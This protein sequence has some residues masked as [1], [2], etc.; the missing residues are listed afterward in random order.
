MDSDLLKAGV[1]AHHNALKSMDGKLVTSLEDY[2]IVLAALGRM[3]A[4][5]PESKVMSVYDAFGK[6]VDKDVPK[7][8]MATVKEADAQAAYKGLMEFKDV[9]KGHPITAKAVTS[10]ASPKIEA[11]AAKLA[12][13]SYPFLQDI[14]WSSPLAAKMSG[15][16]G[17]TFNA[18]K[19]VD[20]A[21]LMGYRVDGGA[22]KEAAEAHVK[23]I[24]NMDANGV[25]TKA[26]YQAILA[27]LGKVVASVPIEKTTN[28]FESFSKVVDPR[29]P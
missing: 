17:V 28:V 8:L 5:V 14:D 15:F 6:L 24:N 26:D 10:P 3:I 2:E 4:S 9:V 1:Y 19:A 22:L 7:Y 27:G 25:T 21:L 20:T 23:A 29:V 18:L 11:A 16:T 13:A 12:D